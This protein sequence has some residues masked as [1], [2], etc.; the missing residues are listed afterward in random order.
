L[1]PLFGSELITAAASTPAFGGDT[2]YLA[3]R[4]RAP[5]A[6]RERADSHLISEGN[7]YEFST[8]SKTHRFRTMKTMPPAKPTQTENSIG[9]AAARRV[10][11]E[12]RT[13]LEPAASAKDAV[14][15]APSNKDIH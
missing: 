14:T 11:H 6:H 4:R 8:R 2:A 9:S 12:T 5:K 13:T 15:V 7:H 10:L 3:W 1:P